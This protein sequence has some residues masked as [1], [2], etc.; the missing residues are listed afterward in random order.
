M[1]PI[2]SLFAIIISSLTAIIQLSTSA[3]LAGLSSKG[4]RTNWLTD[5]H[6]SRNELIKK[7]FQYKPPEGQSGPSKFGDLHSKHHFKGA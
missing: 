1:K 5:S 3:E 7:W 4:V 6:P 2:P